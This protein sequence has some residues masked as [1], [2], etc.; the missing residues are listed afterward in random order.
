VMGSVSAKCL[1]CKGITS[2][3]TIDACV[4]PG[5]CVVIRRLPGSIV[6]G[7]VEEI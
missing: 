3:V 4:V 1:R 6:G 2:W 5:V 7:E